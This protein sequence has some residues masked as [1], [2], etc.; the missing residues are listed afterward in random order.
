MK[1]TNITGP[2]P[3]TAARVVASDLPR[4]AARVWRPFTN[5][6]NEAEQP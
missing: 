3:A 5:T 2:M 6:A 1:C 4:D